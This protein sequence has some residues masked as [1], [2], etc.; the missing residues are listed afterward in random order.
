[1]FQHM[2]SCWSD[3]CAECCGERQPNQCSTRP[4][5]PQVLLQDPTLMLQLLFG[6]CTSYQYRQYRLSGPECY[7]NQNP[8]PGQRPSFLVGC[9]VAALLCVS[10]T[11]DTDPPFIPNIANLHC[12]NTVLLQPVGKVLH[13]RQREMRGGGERGK[14]F[15]LNRCCM[16]LWGINQRSN[17]SYRI[18][19][20]KTASVCLSLS[21]SNSFQLCENQQTADFSP[22]SREF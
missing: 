3:P 22:N 13:E 11:M 17:S 14:H 9:S 8:K 12:N 15:E 4:D 20:Y 19:E 16:S 7:Q 1:M 21:L 2:W 18:H 6:P 5:V 10:P